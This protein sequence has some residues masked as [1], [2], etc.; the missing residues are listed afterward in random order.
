MK[1]S[2]IYAEVEIGE[3]SLT[4]CYDFSGTNAPEIKPFHFS[5]E[6][7]ASKRV[8]L[9]C[10]V[11]DGDPPFQFRWFKDG[12]SLQQTQNLLI[13]T[14][15]DLYISNLVIQKLGPA[16]NGNYTCRVSN[17]AGSDEHSESLL[18]RGKTVST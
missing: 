11:I 12:I 2:L 4:L 8:T 3:L 15:D 1:Y 17:S 18:M 13:R 7:K 14:Q 9:M 16:D 5:G 6:L 10:S